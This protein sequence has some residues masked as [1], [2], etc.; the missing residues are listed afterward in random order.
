M[1]SQIFK[2]WDIGIGHE[3]IS[4]IH[5]HNAGRVRRALRRYLPNDEYLLANKFEGWML[6][7]LAGV[8]YNP[9]IR[10]A[11]EQ[12]QNEIYGGAAYRVNVEK[13]RKAIQ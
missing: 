8:S 12:M 11:V 1:L 9:D 3:R 2:R 6:L 4:F 7:R 10:L 5:C 13:L